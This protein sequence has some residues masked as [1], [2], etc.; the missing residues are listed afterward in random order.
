M[1]SLNFSLLENFFL[2]MYFA[3][4]W[5]DIDF[6][7]FG[8]N[9]SG[10][11]EERK[12]ENWGML[13]QVEQRLYWNW[14]LHHAFRELTSAELKNNVRCVR[15]SIQSVPPDCWVK[16]RHSIWSCSTYQFFTCWH[17]VWWEEVGAHNSA[18]NSQ[19]T[20]FVVMAS[21]FWHPR[22]EHAVIFRKVIP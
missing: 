19:P 22:R 4:F 12:V 17:K 14:Q 8:Q 3:I 9:Y 5:K 20:G 13:A 1:S 7:S 16:W 15:W 2:S 18:L 21:I 6:F 11:K 10:R